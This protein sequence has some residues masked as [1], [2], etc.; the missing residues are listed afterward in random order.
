MLLRSDVSA[1]ACASK[2]TIRA[3]RRLPSERAEQGG[4]GAMGDGS[5]KAISSSEEAPRYLPAPAANLSY[6]QAAAGAR[7]LQ[8][9]AR[10]TF[11]APVPDLSYAQAAAHDVVCKKCTHARSNIQTGALW[12]AAETRDVSATSPRQSPT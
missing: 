1:V 12:P 4:S 3:T 7:S 5:S 8:E 6:A 11:P 10:M 2:E 9:K